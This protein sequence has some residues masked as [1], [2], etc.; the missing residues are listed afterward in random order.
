MEE[1]LKKENKDM[2]MILLTNI[3]EESSTL[4]FKGPRAKEILSA[5]YGDHFDGDT[6]YLPGV[7]SRK[8][9]LIPDL[10]SA[11]RQ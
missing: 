5:A 11:I 7:V 3:L 4:L 2:I 6:I 1:L 9:Q 10:I 8:K